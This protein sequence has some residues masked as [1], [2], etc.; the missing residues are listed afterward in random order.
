MAQ[1]RGHH[2][3]AGV[4]DAHQFERALHRAVLAVAAVQRDERA[5]ASRRASS[6]NNGPLGRIE[7]RAHRRPCAAALRA[8]LPPVISEISRSARAAAHQH[9]HLAEVSHAQP[10]LARQP[11]LRRCALRA[12]AR[13]RICSRT[14]GLRTRSISASISRRAGRAAGLTMKFACLSETCAPPMRMAL[15]PAGF[16]QARGIVARRIAEH[17][18][19]VGL[20]QRLRGDASAPAARWIDRARAA[21]PS[22]RGKL[23]ARGDEPLFARRRCRHDVAVA[24]VVIRRACAARSCAA[25]GRRSSRARRCPR[26]RRRSSRRSSPAR[27]RPCRECRPGIRR[28]AQIMIGGEARQLRARHAGFGVNRRRPSMRD[29]A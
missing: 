3:A 2:A 19:G 18:A 13:C 4:G 26:F 16:D 25:R 27:R 21:A 20:V 5:R 7:A 24:D 29:L 22:P 11:L 14:V 8:P 1:R 10:P 17:R 12:P 9:R 23:E 28:R 6:S 15:E